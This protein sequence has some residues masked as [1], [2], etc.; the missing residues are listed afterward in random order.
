VGGPYRMMR[1]GGVIRHR[2]SDENH[3]GSALRG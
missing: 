2:R 3:N 1:E